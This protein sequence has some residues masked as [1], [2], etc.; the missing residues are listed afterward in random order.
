M[1]VFI[2]HPFFIR[3]SEQ[4]DWMQRNG[5]FWYIKPRSDSYKSKYKYYIDINL[6]IN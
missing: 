5:N 3:L 2:P 1:R 4:K 6:D